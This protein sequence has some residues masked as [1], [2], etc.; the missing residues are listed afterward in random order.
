M[1]EDEEEEQE[2][3][4]GEKKR[5]ERRQSDTTASVCIALSVGERLSDVIGSGQSEA[6]A[7]RGPIRRYPSFPAHCAWI[8]P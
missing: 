1:E 6:H 5:E 8:A 3:E 2:E 4:G 7:R